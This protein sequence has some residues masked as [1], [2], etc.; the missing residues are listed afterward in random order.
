MRQRNGRGRVD[1]DCCTIVAL[2]AACTAGC[3]QGA[4]RGRGQVVRDVSHCGSVR[5]WLA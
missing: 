3:G 5:R 1:M 2:L 4:D